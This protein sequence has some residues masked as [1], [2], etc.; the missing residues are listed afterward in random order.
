M[1]TGNRQEDFNIEEK[2]ANLR[3]TPSQRIEAVAAL[4]TAETAVRMIEAVMG[5]MR[6]MAE[7]LALKPGLKS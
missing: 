6:R 2:L 3:L 1:A 5:G 4:R 7:L